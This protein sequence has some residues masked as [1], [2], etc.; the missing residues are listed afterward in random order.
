MTEENVFIILNRVDLSYSIS[1]GL[2]TIRPQV[3]SNFKYLIE[4][5]RFKDKH[6]SWA[7]ASLALTFSAL[8]L[9]WV[10]FHMHTNLFCSEIRD[11]SQSIPTWPLLLCL[12]APT[13]LYFHHIK[14]IDFVEFGS[15]SK[16]I[17]KSKV[18][19]HTTR[20]L[21]LMLLALFIASLKNVL[22]TLQSWLMGFLLFFWHRFFF[23]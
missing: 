7:L 1:L 8:L 11:H 21:S 6:L 22:I 15:C 20:D 23:K 14:T 19:S 4:K 9:C 2:T 16:H 17:S 13:R 12:V 18:V 5:R 10:W 3:V